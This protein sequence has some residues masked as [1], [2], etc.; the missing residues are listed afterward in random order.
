LKLPPFVIEA[1]LRKNSQAQKQVYECCAPYFRGLVRRYISNVDDAEDILQEGFIRLFEKT[2]QYANK[3]SF[4]GWMRNIFVNAALT[5]CKKKQLLIELDEHIHD[6]ISADEEFNSFEQ[7]IDAGFNQQVL[8]ELLHKL[9]L[10]FQLVFNLYCI[11]GYPHDEIALM[12]K[13]DV[14]TSRT[15]LNRARKLLQRE[16]SLLYHNMYQNEKD[17][18]SRQAI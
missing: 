3:G 17:A 6:E 4:E 15:R 1:C 18:S 12:L 2:N 7:M 13:I 10:P 9:P 11:D 14:T 8:L 16:L 5:Y